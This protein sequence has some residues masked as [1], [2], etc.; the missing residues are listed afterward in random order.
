MSSLIH[1]VLASP[2]RLASYIVYKTRAFILLALVLIY[3]YMQFLAYKKL[4]IRS[5]ARFCLEI[6]TI[7]HYHFDYVILAFIICFI[8]WHCLSYLEEVEKLDR[9]FVPEK[10]RPESQFEPVKTLPGFQAPVWASSDGETFF[11]K[12]QCFRYH[13]SLITARHVIEDMKVIR[14]I[15]YDGAYVDF[16]A[17]S[18]EEMEVDATYVTVSPSD[19]S[20]LRLSSAKLA[21]V[22][23]ANGIFCSATAYGQRSFGMVKPHTA[24]GY[25]E[26]TGS[27][28]GGF[29]GAPYYSGKTVFGMHVGGDSKNI[30]FDITYIKAMF[31]DEDSSEWLIGQIDR[32]QEFES[33]QSPFDSD[34]YFLRIGGTYHVVDFETYDKVL[35][36]KGSK[37]K[38]YK[39]NPFPYEQES[40]EKELSFLA[41]RHPQEAVKVPNPQVSDLKPVRQSKATFTDHE[42]TVDASQKESTSTARRDASPKNVTPKATPESRS[43]RKRR[44]LVINGQRSMRVRRRNRSTFTTESI[45]SPKNELL[46]QGLETTL[47]NCLAQLRS[48]SGRTT[49][50]ESTSQK[51]TTPTSG[52]SSNSI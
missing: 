29:S 50:G 27:T 21:S 8:L 16:P 20:R 39:H 5:L 35:K 24:F 25:V 44:T 31:Y 10:V 17:S 47:V 34:E 19:M 51:P 36:A 14:V 6:L 23:P 9:D 40:F 28:I 32:Y 4:V 7:Y 52:S 2:F 46:M 30:G 22:V 38:G 26:Y 1:E 33:Q 15:G 48:L 3:L 42:I 13:D 11:P 12:G 49:P 37:R 45:E 43:P 41:Q 18:F